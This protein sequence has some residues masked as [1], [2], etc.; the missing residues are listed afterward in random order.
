[1]ESASG[2]RLLKMGVGLTWLFALG[3]FFVA[4]DTT[5]AWLGQR[6][7]ALL[8]VVHAIEFCVFLPTLRRH[9]GSLLGHWVGVMLFG[10][11]HFAGVRQELEAE[12]SS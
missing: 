11:I 4:T 12:P 9:T 3:S 5:L 1:M 10:V 6:L 2:R 8:L 7:F